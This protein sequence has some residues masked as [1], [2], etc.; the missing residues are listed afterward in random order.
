MKPRLLGM[1][2]ARTGS[3]RV[4][5]KNIRP[6]AGHPLIAYAIASARESGLFDRIVV[7]T[8][9]PLVQKIAIHYGAEA[10]FL[11]PEEFAT[12]TSPD[13]DFLEHAFREL[14][15]RFDYFAMLRITSPF[16]QASTIHEAFEI[17]RNTPEADSIRAV[18]LCR[19]HPGKMWKIE[20]RLM[21]PLLAQEGL[22]LPWHARQY[23]DMPKVYVQTSSLEIARYEVVARYRSREGK[24]IAP[25]VTD[26]FAG[27]SIDYEDDWTLAER[28]VETGAARLPVVTAEPYVLPP[29]V[30]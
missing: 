23:Q 9:S 13:I 5:G 19:E 10:P 15:E 17:L 1:I 21:H 20:G 30:A 12:S 7:S 18:R 3:L 26:A 24:V 8:N 14:G 11:R 28:W 6:L 2:P 29:E 16:R 27:F 22:E 25:F 4:K